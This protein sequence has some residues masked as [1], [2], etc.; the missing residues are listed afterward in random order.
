MELIENFIAV[1]RKY[2]VFS[3][4]STR[5]EYWL[6]LL[7]GLIL[8][9]VLNVLALIPGIGGVFTVLMSIIGIALFVPGISVVVRRLHDVGRPGKHYL[10]ILIPL[11]GLILLIMWTVKEGVPEANEYGPNPKTA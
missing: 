11:V 3:G 6:F 5:R 2:A 8:S 9:I 7:C 1:L 4:R 10:V